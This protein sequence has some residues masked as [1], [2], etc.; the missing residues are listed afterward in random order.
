VISINGAPP[1]TF[2]PRVWDALV[3]RGAPVTVRWR[4]AGAEHE[5]S[6]PIVELR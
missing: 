2:T 6:F 1:S 4:H 3:A 5:A